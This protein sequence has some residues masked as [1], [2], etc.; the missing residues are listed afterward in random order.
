M[1]DLQGFRH[2]EFGFWLASATAVD[3]LLE[4]V[5]KRL[6]ARDWVGAVVSTASSHEML[7]IIL[8]WDEHFAVDTEFH[9]ITYRYKIR[10]RLN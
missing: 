8:S 10:E 2:K 7:G 3:T 1:V 9:K 6:L 5:P 4:S